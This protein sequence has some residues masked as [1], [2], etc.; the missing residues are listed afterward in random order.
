MK[1][2]SDK[3]A[4]NNKKIKGKKIDSKKP[5]Q[6]LHISKKDTISEREQI[7]DDTQSPSKEVKTKIEEIGPQI[8]E[9][10]T[11]EKKE[12]YPQNIKFENNSYQ[13]LTKPSNLF[14]I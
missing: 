11:N 3:D 9:A 6:V 5:L 14:I 1:G 12:K 7:F 8:I 4:P 13:D 10:P 2:V